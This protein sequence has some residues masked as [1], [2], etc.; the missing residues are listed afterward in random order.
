M[1]RFAQV[2]SGGRSQTGRAAS[3]AV[4]FDLLL[5]AA[6]FLAARRIVEKFAFAVGAHACNALS[7]VECGQLTTCLYT[8]ALTLD[9]FGFVRCGLGGA[10]RLGGTTFPKRGL[11]IDLLVGRLW[12]GAAC[13]H[14]FGCGGFSRWPCRTAQHFHFACR[15]R[16]IGVMDSSVLV[17]PAIY[18]SGRRKRDHEGK[19]EGSGANHQ[20][21]RKATLTSGL[22]G[23]YNTDLVE[24]I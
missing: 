14:G 12:R 15:W 22:S 3:V 2:A 20:D 10:I 18:L 1:H 13:A 24:R 23:L 6:H 9:V 5:Q 19:Q 16:Q 21:L 17:L 4:L 8:E 7:G 11:W